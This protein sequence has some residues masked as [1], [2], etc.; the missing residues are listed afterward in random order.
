MQ[1]NSFEYFFFFLGITFFYFACPKSFRWMVLLAGSYFFYIYWNPAYVGLIAISTVISYWLGQKISIQES[2]LGK[3]K[4]LLVGVGINLTF[5]FLFKYF[6]FFNDL[7]STILDQF[8]LENNIG[9]LNF[10]LPVGI[11][12]YTFQCLGYLVDVYRGNKTPETHLGIF[13]LYISFF[14]QLVAGP[15]ER[16]THFLP[17]LRV[18]C[19]F[20]P[21]RISSGLRLILWGLFKKIVIADRLGIYVN[22]VYNNVPFHRGPSFLLATYFFAFQIYCDFSAYSDIARG[23]ARIL[24]YE[25]L[26]NFDYPYFSQSIGDFWRRWHI[27][28]SNWFRDYLYIPLGGSRTGNRRTYFN[29]FFVFLVC[30]L[31]HGANLTF[32][33]WGGIH[34]TYL[35][36]SRMTKDLR[37]AI[38]VSLNLKKF[39]YLLGVLRIFVTFN[40][41]AFTWIYFRANSVAD[42]NAIVAALM[43]VSNY[44]FQFTAITQ[45]IYGLFGIILLVSIEALKNFWP[46]LQT[47]FF[48]FRSLRWGFYLFL[49]LNVA[50]MGVF[51]GGQFIYFQF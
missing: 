8:N 30:G 44:S 34:G 32:V 17:Q 18:H 42:G 20:D 2:V 39:P 37:S 28:L 5:L 23:S 22:S 49:L 41:V 21:E 40:L 11:S 26:K 51:D 16:S 12:F 48:A 43:N 9:Y 47:S 3:R 15:I 38:L 10:L 25:L 27:T 33:I 45:I 1:F 36:L 35:V 31:W 7:F 13:A 4:Y 46:G 50:L 6:N 19:K 29:L 24:G 14:P